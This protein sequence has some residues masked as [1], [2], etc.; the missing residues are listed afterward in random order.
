M[1]MCINTQ[2]LYVV[3]LHIGCTAVCNVVLHTDY[4]NTLLEFYYYVIININLQLLWDGAKN[5]MLCVL[6][7]TRA[8]G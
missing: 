6:N 1:H 7:S 2:I 8:K 4:T 3:V 5:S